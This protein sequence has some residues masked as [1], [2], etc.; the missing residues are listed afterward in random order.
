MKSIDY[1][2]DSLR[3][4]QA[5][6]TLE[7]HNKNWLLGD[8]AS[9]SRAI[10]EEIEHC[11]KMVNKIRKEMYPMMEATNAKHANDKN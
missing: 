1:L 11:L 4:M 9:R 3:V 7:Y 5:R 2:E 8:N 6:E 10:Q